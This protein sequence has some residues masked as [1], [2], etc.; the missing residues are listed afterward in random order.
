MFEEFLINREVKGARVREAQS[1]QY[2]GM[3]CYI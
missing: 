3:G 1:G 2:S